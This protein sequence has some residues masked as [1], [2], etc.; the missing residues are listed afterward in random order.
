MPVPAFRVLLT[1]EIDPEGVE[2]L[3]AEAALQVDVVP[4]LP[5]EVLLERI[6][7]Y[8]ALI[9][10]SATR[11]SEALLRRGTRLRAVG[12]AGVGVDNVALDAATA[13]GIAV[14]NAPAGNT[15]A[16]AELFFGAVLGALRHIPR[17]DATMHGG[18]WDRSRLLGAELQG[19]RLGLIGL[20][21]IGTEVAKRARAFG[22]TVIG[23]D[24]YVSG[25]RFHALQVR[26]TESLETLL[27][28]ADILTVHTPLTD[29]TRGMIGSAELALLPPGALVVNMARGGIVDEAAL[30]AALS[31]DGSAARCSTSTP[32]N[33]CLPITRSARPPT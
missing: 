5:A 22:M 14:I 13:L 28:Q 33:H 25:E 17:A 29:E 16:V 4:T 23:Y 21:R 11:V 1:D 30:L 19:R 15:I 2:L 20:G 7:E 8:D 27:E 32:S 9:G 3:A 10:R 24:P 6:G 18:R 12:R 31:G 26:R